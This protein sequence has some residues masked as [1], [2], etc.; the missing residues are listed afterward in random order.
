MSLFDRLFGA[1]K[2]PIPPDIT[3]G[4]YT[5]AYKS[6]EQQAAF[7]RSLEAFERGER[8]PAYRDFLSFLKDC[9]VTN[10]CQ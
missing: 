4:R 1:S 10:F 6:D 9:F 3:F 2:K 8:M 5:D 7:D